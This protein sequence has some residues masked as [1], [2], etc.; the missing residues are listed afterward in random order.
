LRQWM[1]TGASKAKQASLFCQAKKSA[2]IF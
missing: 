1:T 2:A